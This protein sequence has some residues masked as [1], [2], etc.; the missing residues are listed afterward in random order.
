MGNFI[1]ATELF[2]LALLIIFVGL[3]I[4]P[5]WQWA[6]HKGIDPIWLSEDGPYEVLGTASV[7]A[8]AFLFLAA[9]KHSSTGDYPRRNAFYLLAA[10]VLFI[11]VGEEI[12]W[13]ERMFD[14]TAPEIITG[15]NFQGEFN[16]HNSTIIQDSNN[17]HARALA[18]LLLLYLAI[19]PMVLL[20]FP[21]IGK[22]FAAIRVPTPSLYV[23]LLAGLG[24]MAN[25]MNY[26]IIYA[27][28]PGKDQIRVGEAY[29]SLQEVLLFVVALECFLTVKAKQNKKRVKTPTL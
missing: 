10:I 27:G 11:L 17:E 7:F 28:V 13:G 4:F 24:K 5:G 23:A 2:K 15:Q 18:R 9:F 25:S 26:T 3:A 21:S 22:W 29:E 16:L 14:F 1:S 6:M 8:A 12:S 20:V 19:L